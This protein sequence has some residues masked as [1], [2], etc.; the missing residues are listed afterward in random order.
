MRVAEALAAALTHRAAK[1]QVMDGFRATNRWLARCN[2]WVYEA[3]T[4]WTPWLYGASYRLTRGLPPDHLFWQV[5]T[6]SSGRAVRRAVLATKPDWI[7]QVFPDHALAAPW[8]SGLL[9]GDGTGWRPRVGVVLTDFAIHPHWFHRHVDVY[10]L[11][12]ENLIP[13][14]ARWQ[15]AGSATEVSGI[16][17]RP[18]FT[19]R[20]DPPVSEPYV[21]VMTGGRGVLPGWTE[22]LQ[23]LLS[24]LPDHA[25]YVLCGRNEGMRERVAHLGWPRVH[26]VG[27]VDQVAAWL[28]HAALAV[29]KAGGVSVAEALASGCPQ[30]LYRPQPGQEAENAAWVERMGVG[31]RANDPS[32]LRSAI[33]AL[34]QRGL[35]KGMEAVCRA[36]GRPQ[37]ADHVAAY[38][39]SRVNG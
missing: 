22:A 33:A 31:L 27:F 6:I 3:T 13:A 20:H 17:L 23:V 34:R 29:G 1:V 35:R 15:E 25:V 7:L 12:H 28:Q 39:V 36:A 18:Q 2:E 30:V 16:P 21:V 24:E 4:R 26:A 11:P 38:I 10:F 9:A 19:E 8:F 14:A 37:A 5:L 32:E